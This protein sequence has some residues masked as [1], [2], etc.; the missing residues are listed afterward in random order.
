M[1]ALSDCFK[2]QGKIDICHYNLEYKF[3]KQ[4]F[5]LNLNKYMSEIMREIYSSS[6][7]LELLSLNFSYAKL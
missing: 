4:I 7:H 2:I 1:N 5:E 3:E 6:F